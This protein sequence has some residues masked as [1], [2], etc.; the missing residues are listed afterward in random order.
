M[1]LTGSRIQAD[2]FALLRDSALARAING[3]VYLKGTR[4]RD[5]RLEDAVVIFK[6]GL[7]GQMQDGVVTVNVFVPDITPWGDGTKTED[8]ARTTAIEEAA[9]QWADGLT[10]QSRHL[11]GYRFTLQETVHTQAEPATDE[12]FVVVHLRYQYYND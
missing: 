6:K 10:R 1:N 7:P 3:H 5:S 8:I 9:E 4:P 12:H 11:G 2:V